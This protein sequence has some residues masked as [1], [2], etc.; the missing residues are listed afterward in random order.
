[1]YADWMPATA[2]WMRG[3]CFISIIGV[4]HRIR[5]VS[6]FA[7]TI[8]IY[9]RFVCDRSESFRLSLIRNEALEVTIVEEHCISTNGKWKCMSTNEA[10]LKHLRMAR[11]RRVPWKRRPPLLNR[12]LGCGM[13]G[14]RRVPPEVNGRA[15]E[16]FDV[17]VLT[18]MGHQELDPLQCVASR[19]DWQIVARRSYATGEPSV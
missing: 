13:I 4:L 14:I 6:G 7:C 17:A 8:Q 1:M 10:V 18:A 9:F 19:R 12:L 3:R 2:Y 11:D 5:A 16:L 15:P